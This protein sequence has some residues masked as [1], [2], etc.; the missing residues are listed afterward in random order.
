MTGTPVDPLRTPP[1][2]SSPDSTTDADAGA[3][4]SEE[5]VTPSGAVREQRPHWATPIVRGWAILIAVIAWTLKQL[6]DSWQPGQRLPP[7]RAILLVV[8]AVLALTLVQAAI[9]YFQWRTTT[10]RID[11]DEVRVDHRFIQHSSDRISLSKIQSV[12]VVQPFAARLLG[13]ARLRI[14]VG[15]SRA[16]SIEYLPRAEAYRFRDFLIGQTHRAG[17][18]V[19]AEARQGPG[20]Y[21]EAEAGARTSSWA[22][23]HRNP[24]PGPE[25]PTRP[26]P[27]P[28]ARAPI[29]SAWQDRRSDESAVATVAPRQ[30]ILATLISGSFIGSVLLAG[31]GIALPVVLHL[32]A[33][34]LPLVLAALLTAVR[35]VT[36][37]LVKYW[38]FTLLRADGGLKM[39]HGLTTLA[40]RTIPCRRI[41]GVEIG[42]PLLWR[43]AGLY[44]V[45]LTVLGGVR[46]DGQLEAQMLLPVS[47]AGQVR[48][49][50]DAIWPGVSLD[51]VTLHPIPRRARWLRWLDRQTIFWGRDDRIMVA[52]QGLLQR[53]TEVVPHSRVQSIGL[54]Q[55]PLQRRLRLADVSLHLPAGPVHLTCRQLDV[56]DARRLLLDEMDLCRAARSAELRG[57]SPAPTIDPHRRVRK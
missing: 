42:Q 17:A 46:L 39:V 53:H 47:T 11:E 38:R 45:R 41:Q 35:A 21:P 55:G 37:L 8:G 1:S 43:A 28:G 26:T 48:E 36:G 25:R 14:D 27:S 49:T 31:I 7:V 29:G 2:T 54:R 30:I 19:D 5:T 3:P 24:H 40:T 12:D 33:I 13:L 16:H 22:E 4:A 57:P 52:R 23:G 56:R 44:R 9:G 51:A 20:P 18:P 50:I 34:T 10:F 6:L 32:E 15:G